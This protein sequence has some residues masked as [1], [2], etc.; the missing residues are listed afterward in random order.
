MRDETLNMDR[1]IVFSIDD[2]SFFDDFSLDDIIVDG[3][4]S[5]VKVGGN[6]PSSDSGIN[7]NKDVSD[8]VSDFKN[9]KTADVRIGGSGPS[10]DSNVNSNKDVF[11]LEDDFEDDFDFDVGGGNFGFHLKNKIDYNGPRKDQQITAADVKE[12]SKRFYVSYFGFNPLIILK[13]KPTT[14]CSVIRQRPNPLYLKC[15]EANING[16]RLKRDELN[17]A[18]GVGAAVV[19]GF[20]DYIE[21]YLKDNFTDDGIC[22]S[23]EFKQN[24]LKRYAGIVNGNQEEFIKDYYIQCKAVVKQFK[25]NW[26]KIQSEINLKVPSTRNVLVTSYISRQL[27]SGSGDILYLF[28]ADSNGGQKLDSTNKVF[29]DIIRNMD[30]YTGLIEHLC[31]IVSY[32]AHSVNSNSDND[33]R[34]LDDYIKRNYNYYTMGIFKIPE[35]ALL[36]DMGFPT[37][38]AGKESLLK[39]SFI[40]EQSKT[41]GRKPKLKNSVYDS[42]LSN[43]KF[44]SFIFSSNRMRG[45]KDE[46]GH[47]W[48]AGRLK[49]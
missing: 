41:K 19:K 30:S 27:K 33:V 38:I 6:K 3:E 18:K 49:F 32:A 23:Q 11:D 39:S 37:S 20:I 21:D 16:N 4:T 8:S 28:K 47:Y 29:A 26:K 46:D 22:I 17:N 24:L 2:D 13:E 9:D 5:G 14:L 42:V 10:L 15:L 1:D 31:G 34:E 35:L 36:H 43:N 44:L 40:L 48:S 7:S 45:A 12:F 25:E